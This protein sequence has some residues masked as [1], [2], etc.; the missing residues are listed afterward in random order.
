MQFPGWSIAGDSL[1]P[2]RGA[3]NDFVFVNVD[4][5]ATLHLVPAAHPNIADL[6]WL[7]RVDQL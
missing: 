1:A 4:Q 3:P 5:F 7:Y 2:F 6:L